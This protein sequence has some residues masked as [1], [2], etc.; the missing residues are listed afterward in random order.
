M[1]ARGVSCVLRP[2]CRTLLEK[3]TKES[4]EYFEYMDGLANR[5]GKAFG[6]LL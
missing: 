5:G 6:W 1:G 3:D 4:F 2:I